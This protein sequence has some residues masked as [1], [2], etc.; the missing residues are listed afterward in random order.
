MYL[1]KKNISFHSFSL[2][3]KFINPHYAWWMTL[4]KVKHFKIEAKPST[5]PMS[6]EF[7]IT[8]D[9]AAIVIGRIFLT[10][11]QSQCYEKAAAWAVQKHRQRKQVSEHANDC[12]GCT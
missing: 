7:M 6:K 2:V 5:I 4:K 10:V 9:F 8:L 3:K 1:D 11:R 12:R